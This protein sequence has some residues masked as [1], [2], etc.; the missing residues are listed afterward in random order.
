MQCNCMVTL[1]S[2][3]QRLP[4]TNLAQVSRCLELGSHFALVTLS[5][6]PAAASSEAYIQAWIA[7]KAAARWITSLPLC[8]GL[9]QDIHVHPTSRNSIKLQMSL[10]VLRRIIVV[11]R[12]RGDGI[13]TVS[14]AVAE[15]SDPNCLTSLFLQVG[16][17]LYLG[18]MLKTIFSASKKLEAE[19]AVASW[20]ATRMLSPPY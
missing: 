19:L 6:I 12:R 16:L 1:H 4:S 13:A 17:P 10:C 20:Q 8:G 14:A 18:D 3:L 5:L 15:V 7:T 2:R 11:W 9:L